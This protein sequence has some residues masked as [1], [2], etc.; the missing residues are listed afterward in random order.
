MIM[1][2]PFAVDVVRTGRSKSASIEVDGEHVR[3]LVPNTL[4]DQR[5]NDLI[6]KRSVWIKQKLAVHASTPEPSQR[7]FVNGEAFP[8]LGRNYRLK[9]LDSDEY[10]VKLKH[11]YLVVSYRVSQDRSKNEAKVRSLLMTWYKSHA[12]DKLREKTSRYSGLIG[13]K[14]TSVTVQDYKARWGSCLDSGE[15]SFNWKIIL[16]PHQIVDYLVIHEL[17]HLIEHNHSPKFW[18]AV[19]NH[20]PDYPRHRQWLKDHGAEL[21][22]FLG[23][24]V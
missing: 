14:P 9:L 4:S 16:A 24:D 10:S 17:C 15:V 20:C 8:Y 13:V 1:D 12:Y 3:V 23:K 7:E 21:S 18:K 19:E 11:G 2:F 22:G 6:S 5:I